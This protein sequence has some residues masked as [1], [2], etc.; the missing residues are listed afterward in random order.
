MIFK[1]Q[2][3]AVAVA[4]L[5][6]VAPGVGFCG[7]TL[8]VQKQVKTKKEKKKREYGLCRKISGI[9]I[10][11]RRGTKQSKKRWGSPQIGG[12]MVSHRNVVLS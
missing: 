6:M 9:S 4:L 8:L 2:S 3:F 11:M 10:Q 1:F 7:G 5:R 12:V